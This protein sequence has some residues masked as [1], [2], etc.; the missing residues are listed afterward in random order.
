M[1]RRHASPEPQVASTEA[2][3]A[4]LLQMTT[5]AGLNIPLCSDAPLFEI[6][7]QGEW[8][9]LDSPLPTKF[10]RLFAS[11]LHCVDGTH[12][13]ITPVEK[14]VVSVIDAPLFVVDYQVDIPCDPPEN[15]ATADRVL[16]P[17]TRLTCTSSIGTQHTQIQ[18]SA[19]RINDTGIY[20]PLSR[21]LWG[22]LNRACYYHFVNE[23]NLAE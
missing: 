15:V 3:T 10:A 7:A 5:Q 6:D 20:L 11:I 19:L 16:S 21:G 14:V 9:Y 17:N 12:L 18:A 1:N 8:T 2:D 23:F 22:K 13:L 4:S